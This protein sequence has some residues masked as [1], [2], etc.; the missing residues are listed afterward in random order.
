MVLDGCG[1]SAYRLLVLVGLNFNPLHETPRHTTSLDGQWSFQLD[2]DNFGDQE[3]WQAP[4]K[5]LSGTIIVPGAWDAQGYGPETD[6]MRHNFIGKGWYKRTVYVPAAGEG[7]R[8][9]L[10]FGGVYRDVRVWVNGREAG[11]H[12]GYVSQFEFD[13]TPFVQP[14]R[15]AEITLC[16]NSKQQ[17][18]IDPLMGCIDIIDHLFSFWGGIQGHVDLERRNATWLDEL[19]V[20]PQLSADRV[21]VSARVSGAA[22]G[23][24]TV[25]LEVFGPDGNQA[26]TSELLLIRAFA[27]ERL[28]ISAGL[29]GAPRWTP[30][31]P[32]LHRGRLTLLQGQ[33]VVDTI[34][35]RFGMRSIEIRG[36]DFYVNGIKY[37]LNGYGDDAVYVE[38][39]APPSDKQF[40]LDRLK[41]AKNYGFN[42]VRHHSHFV[43]PEYYE[44]CDEIG[45]FVSPELPIAYPRFYNRA[46]GVGRDLYL[47]E[48]SVAIIRYRNHPS[49]FDWC[50]GNEL[51]DGVDLA[52]QFM[53]VARKLDPT[54]PFVDSDGLFPPG[55]ID[56]TKDRPTLDFYSVMFEILTLPLENP[57]KFATGT[58]LKPIVGHEEGNFVHFP[59]LDSIPLYDKTPFKPFWLTVARDKIAEQ[60]LLAETPNWSLQS[61][62]LYYLCHKINLEALRKNPKIS[63][64]HWW[65][66]QPW[67]PGSN[68]LVDIHR[69]DLSNT[70]ERVRQI[71]APIVLLQDGLDL[72]YRGNQTVRLQL[73]TSN[74]SPAALQSPELSWEVRRAGKIV[75]EGRCPAGEVAQ[76]QI[77]P[78]GFIEFKLADSTGPEKFEIKVALKAGGQTVTNQWDSWVYPAKAPALEE[79]HPL[80]ASADLLPMLTA[81]QPKLIP[82]RGELPSPAV[83]VVRQPDERLI[84][85][86]ERGSSVVILSPAGV[87][88]TDVTTFKSAWWL[89]VFPGDSNAGTVVYDSPVTKAMTPDGWCDGGW[90]RLLQGA[91]TVI[92]DDLPAQP[93]VVIRALNVHSAPTG[94]TRELD[95]DFIWRNKS[96][97][98]ETRVGEGSWIVSGL[99]FDSALRHGG[100]E[101]PW[102]LTQ[103]LARAQTLPQPAGA[104]PVQTLRDAVAK[105]AVGSGPLVSGF[106]RVVKH[107]GETARGHSYRETN[108]AILRIR[109]EEAL[110]ELTW[111]TAPAP[112]S[113]RTTFVFA[114]GTSF[115]DPVITNLGFG[116]TVDGVK[117]LNFDS[118]KEGRT[119]RSADDQYT[120][121]FVPGIAESSW[122]ESSGLFY[123]SVPAE[124][125]TAGQ[126]VKI[127][128]HSIGANNSHW[129]KINPYTEVLD[130]AT[131]AAAQR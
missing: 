26:A 44:A 85:V 104:I 88:P 124:A 70:P 60:G 77:V 129:F 61:E 119:W 118:T 27:G 83:Y 90:F 15:P 120:L 122:S 33:Q 79:R 20:Q 117:I 86:A 130:G 49:I 14:G 22:G 127:R 29:P 34:E 95:Y 1:L 65:L 47:K 73:S 102:L 72:N 66:L 107:I 99:N 35:T 100:P 97:L 78:L 5:K 38:T 37:Y 110:H 113:G 48:W 84:K 121:T 131:T 53:N 111:E 8:F 64:Y 103:L 125:V 10:K 128:V 96:L 114:G 123:L 63:G 105:S 109:Q 31:S 57:D 69:R 126:P 2:P 93:D 58:P 4:A 101:G 106:S 12:I 71:N 55:F 41:V 116:L 82:A 3:Q 67:Y 94:F 36:S 24:D 91:Q 17:I 112:A 115:R 7:H 42:F 51:W 11:Y 75:H 98:F 19:F 32:K 18:D 45:M 80:Y 68:G 28:E 30:E 89:G 108:S 50:V 21:L 43:N 87:F 13:V 6:K 54:R 81:Y 23:A 39:I 46:K 40:Y 92:L 25:R 76:G 52:P 62:K 9:Y 16:V 74:Y 59:R 56:G